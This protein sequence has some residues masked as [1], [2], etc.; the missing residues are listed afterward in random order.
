MIE[1][2]QKTV[3][4]LGANPAWQKSVTC[5]KWVSGEV[6]R[7]RLEGTGAA[8]K[9]FNTAR[10]VRALGVPVVLVSASGL[11]SMEWESACRDEGLSTR[12]FPISGR[13][14][15]ATTIQD[16]ATGDVTEMV[17]E[18]YEASEG[19][20]EILSSAL[21]QELSVASF[22]VIA[23]TFPPGLSPKVALECLIDA[24][25]PVLVDSAPTLRSLRD[26]D[27]VPSQLILKLNEAEWTTIF[28]ETQL[29]PALK[30]ARRLWPQA[31]LIATQGKQGAVLW[32][33]DEQSIR[34]VSEPFPQATRLHPIGAGD[35]FSGGF[36]VSMLQGKTI[37]ESAL[38]G[39]AVARASCLNPLPA[40]F[41]WEE[42]SV[43]QG[44][45]RSLE[46]G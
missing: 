14:R 23:G 2:F 17:E 19:A 28:G 46:N 37:L 22:V 44:L 21:R 34:L 12:L 6:V 9:G 10:V 20:A 25:V 13:I 32:S 33:T 3:L 43:S 31:V 1:P 11:D 30:Q 16:L 40:R 24:T 36:V 18:G 4:V 42:F 38:S 35:A 15:T 29:T 26:M 7:V 27:R 39:M 5:A 45:V 41:S 8:G